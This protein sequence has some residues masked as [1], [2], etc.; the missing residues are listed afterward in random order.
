VRTVHA[1][2][3]LPWLAARAP[4]A[5]CSLITSLPDV[6]SFPALGLEGWQR[7]FVDAAEL[8]LR[9]TPDDGVTMFYQTDVK[10]DGTWVDKSRLCHHAAD[11]NGAA[12]LWHKIVCRKPAGTVNFGRPAYSHLLC[13]SRG[14]RDG[15]GH[16]YPDV[17]WVGGGVLMATG[18]TLYLIDAGSSSGTSVQAGCFDSGCGLE[19]TGHF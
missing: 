8:V 7:W 18:L 6:S 13:F 9:S 2:D 19:T 3:A 14:V 1:E 16:A 10:L 17:L 4:L 15:A 5:G 12:L 11:R